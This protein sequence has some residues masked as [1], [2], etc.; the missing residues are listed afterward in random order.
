MSIN[1]KGAIVLLNRW[2]EPGNDGLVDGF[3]KAVHNSDYCRYRER[4]L[5]C[6][7]SYDDKIISLKVSCQKVKHYGVGED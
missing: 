2:G 3:G 7:A 5:D 1:A 4:L 6:G